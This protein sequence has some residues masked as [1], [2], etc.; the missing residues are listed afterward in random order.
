MGRQVHASL[1]SSILSSGSG[2]AVLRGAEHEGLVENTNTPQLGLEFVDAAPE[3]GRLVV[4]VGDADGGTLED[5]GLGRLLVGGGEGSTEAVVSLAELV[6]AALLGLDALAADVLAA[7]L[8]LLAVDGS[9]RKVIVLVELGPVLFLLDLARAAA[10]GASRGHKDG[11]GGGAGTLV[12]ID[13]TTSV[14]LGRG[15][16]LWGASTDTG[17]L[18]E[19][20]A[21]DGGGALGI[22][23]GQGGR[24]EVG[25][26]E[27][28]K[29]DHGG[30]EDG[31]GD[32]RG[33]DG[34]KGVESV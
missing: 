14:A 6:A 5:R 29:G 19:T 1:G 22:G 8:W 17:R 30:V 34:G 23:A 9:R 25:V 31:G 15:L 18:P 13:E 2:C 27:M 32:V 12:A 33:G 16:G 20:T 21:D 26:S 24:G 11:A 4:E 3:G 7:A 10:G 28:V